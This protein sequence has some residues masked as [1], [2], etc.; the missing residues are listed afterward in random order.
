MKSWFLIILNSG[1][2]ISDPTFEEEQL[3]AGLTS[4]T[5]E[6]TS[7]TH[8]YKPGKKISMMFLYLDIT[9][10]VLYRRM[11][12]RWETG[13]K[14]YSAI[15][16]E[17]KGGCKIDWRG[18]FI[19]YCWTMKLFVIPCLVLKIIQFQMSVSIQSFL[20]LNFLLHD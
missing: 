16:I 3:A 10:P 8:M 1:I 17:N 5:M 13:E 14:T 6:G 20:N 2:L 12:F 11:Y 18:L 7:V 15:R 9:F 19:I 4:I